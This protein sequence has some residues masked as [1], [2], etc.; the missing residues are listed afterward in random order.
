M[1]TGLACPGHPQ[2]WRQDIFGTPYA[3]SS[4]RL[5]GFPVL[6][7]PGPPNVYPP[8]VKDYSRTYNPSMTFLINLL[9]RLELK[10]NCQN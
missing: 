2:D 3:A 6:K 4:F 1:S 9:T 5:S 7:N 8:L 10:K